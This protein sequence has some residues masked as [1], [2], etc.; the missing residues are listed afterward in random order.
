VNKYHVLLCIIFWVLALYNV[1]LSAGG[2]LPW[3][4]TE[5][6]NWN[7]NTVEFL[8]YVKAMI[9]LVK[10]MPQV[11]SLGRVAITTLVIMIVLLLYCVVLVM[12]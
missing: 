6:S 9:S 5:K 12:V 8:G 1:A 3:Y 7:Y 4:T 2:I 11:G 10:Y